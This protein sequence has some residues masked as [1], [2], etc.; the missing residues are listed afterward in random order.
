MSELES[1]IKILA[2]A[3]F[4][5]SSEQDTRERAVNPVISALNWDV[6]DPKVVAR[7]YLVHG[8]KV[9][10]CL[11][12]KSKSKSLVLIEVKR[13]GTDLGE[14][15]EQL[16]GYAFREGA[17]LA[18]LTDGLLWWLYL[19]MVGGSWA[20]RRFSSIELCETDTA[21]AAKT[22]RLFLGSESVTS[23]RAQDEAQRAFDSQERERAVRAAL[24]EAWQRVLVDSVMRDLLVEKVKEISGHQPEL[25]M[26]TKFLEEMRKHGGAKATSSAAAATDKMAP[27]KP[28]S[29]SPPSNKPKTKKATIKMTTRVDDNHLVVRFADGHGSRWE[30][31]DRSDKQGIREVRNLAGAFARHH[32]ATEGQVNAVKKAL[33]DNGYHLKR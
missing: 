14:H 6:F 30:L 33:T 5:Q 15:Q 10:Y 21:E 2:E 22:M 1:L 16:L 24:G 26:I 18:V 23:G 12:D 9:D 25:D 28:A 31:P 27:A 20:Q 4:S 7:E 32:G 19:P 17:P 8:G 11:R 13:A 3:D 29:S